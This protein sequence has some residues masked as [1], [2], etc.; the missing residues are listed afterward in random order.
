MVAEA[1]PGL[2]NVVAGVGL[3]PQRV[4]QEGLFGPALGLVRLYAAVLIVL[5]TAQEPRGT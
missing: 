2:G 1:P 3:L 5:V 4:L